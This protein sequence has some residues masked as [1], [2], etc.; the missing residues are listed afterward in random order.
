M[1]QVGP[2]INLV[3]SDLGTNP[4]F[5]QIKLIKRVIVNINNL[6]Y[7]VSFFF[8]PMTHKVINTDPI[9]SPELWP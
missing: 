2:T 9:T 7:K 8:L 1:T 4:K 3:T 6:S 5:N